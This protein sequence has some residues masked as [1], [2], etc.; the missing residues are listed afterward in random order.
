MKYEYVI[1]T[2]STLFVF[3]VLLSRSARARGG[4]QY[5]TF[6]TIRIF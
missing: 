6:T 2:I 3:L 1:G 4:K 5:S